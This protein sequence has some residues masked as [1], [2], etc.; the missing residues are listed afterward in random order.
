MND[1]KLICPECGLVSVIL[2]YKPKNNGT[3][4]SC[5]ICGRYIKFVGKEYF[6]K[7]GRENMGDFYDRKDGYGT[8]LNEYNG[9]YSLVD[10]KNVDETIYKT[11]VFL[12]RWK[13]GKPIP[14]DDKRPM[15]I[16]LGDKES[17]IK[18]LEFFLA[19]LK[20]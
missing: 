11:W 2:E 1:L 20:S 4:A 5:S 12:S 19:K 15:G 14:T 17:A 6:D 13:N 10:A 7:E 18:M 8:E 16:Y 9:N 3:K